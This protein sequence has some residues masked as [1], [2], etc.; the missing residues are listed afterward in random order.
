[1]SQPRRALEIG[2][3]V[4]AGTAIGPRSCATFR[5]VNA[6]HV[7]GALLALWAVVVSFLGI[8]REGFPNTKPA[9]RLVALVSI[10][11]VIG[12]IGT[13][14]YTSAHESHEEGTTE[15]RETARLVPR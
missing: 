2:R 5:G 7:V 9:E 15:G 11:L 14:V 3:G 10:L 6:F 1:M 4:L 12:A 13:A 8:T